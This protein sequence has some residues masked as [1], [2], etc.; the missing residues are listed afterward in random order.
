MFNDDEVAYCLVIPFPKTINLWLN[1]FKK[2]HQFIFIFFKFTPETTSNN[3]LYQSL[4]ITSDY[5]KDTNITSQF[6]YLSTPN[7][8]SL[9]WYPVQN[10]NDFNIQSTSKNLED[11]KICAIKFNTEKV[12]LFVI[13]FKVKGRQTSVKSSSKS[14]IMKIDSMLDKCPLILAHMGGSEDVTCINYESQGSYSFKKP[15]SNRYSY[16]L[17]VFKPTSYTK[18]NLLVNGL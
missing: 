12:Q 4:D 17:V 9:W 14:G 18:L 8:P 11:L 7:Y 13:D 10:I 6:F 1:L 2:T 5:F 16:L 15:S 3:Q